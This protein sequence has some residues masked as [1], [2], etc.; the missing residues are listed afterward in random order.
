[1]PVVGAICGAIQACFAY[2]A[3]RTGRPYY[4][5]FIILAF[6]VAGCVLYY[7]IE[8]YP[9]SRERTRARKALRSLVKSF[10][11]RKELRERAANVESCASVAN[12]VLLARECM[13]QR[14]YADAASLY[15]SCLSGLHEKD[16]DLRFCLATALFSAGELAEAEQLARALRLEEPKFRPHEIAMLLAQALEGLQRFDEASA[17]LRLL[18]EI[19]PG[20]EARWRYGALLKRMGRAAEAREVFA[21]MLE[22]AQQS[23]AHYRAAQ[24]EWLSLARENL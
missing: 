21:R 3:L 18:V 13:E 1:M 20:E 6:P 17:E 22:N 24:K 11:S 16:A 2:H 12:R 15:R 4:W 14:L 9:T 10:Y 7:F 5:V 23:P 8:V 19:Y